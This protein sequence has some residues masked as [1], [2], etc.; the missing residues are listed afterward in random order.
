MH[1]AIYCFLTFFY[2]IIKDQETTNKTNFL[3]LPMAE[4]DPSANF[5]DLFLVTLGLF[6]TFTLCWRLRGLISWLIRW[7]CYLG[8]A[9]IAVGLG[10]AILYPDGF[11]LAQNFGNQHKHHL[12]ESQALGLGRNIIY[13]LVKNLYRSY[14]IARGLHVIIS[15]PVPL[16]TT[17]KI[18]KT[19]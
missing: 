14:S 17:T 10:V 1:P 3:C 2:L 6:I 5:V 18:K 9:A 7:T 11:I 8:I 4:I 13:D 19:T 16:T 15:P 12:D